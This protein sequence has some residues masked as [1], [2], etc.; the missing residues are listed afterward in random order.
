[1]ANQSI[2]QKQCSGCRRV[3]PTSSFCRRKASPDGLQRR[4]KE[5]DRERGR[6]ASAKATLRAW[7]KANRDRLQAQVRAGA[8]GEKRRIWERNYYKKQADVMRKRAS[9]RYH[10][11]VEASRAYQNQWKATHCAEHKAHACN[12]YAKE[13]GSPG[14]VTAKQIIDKF[15]FHGWRCYLCRRPLRFREAV[16]EHRFPLSR[17]GTNFIANIAPSCLP[18]NTKNRDRTEAEYRVHVLK[19]KGPRT[20]FEG[21]QE[22]ALK[23]LS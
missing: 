2:F 12:A 8:R 17:S 19:S 20:E 1:M 13:W 22:A 15:H 5:C 18:C 7:R 3:L 21:L 11:N 16:P 9:K 23:L 4:C 14:R 6:S 10:A